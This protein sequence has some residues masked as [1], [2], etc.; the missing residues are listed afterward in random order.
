M[1][2]ELAFRPKL[3]HT[4]V[5]LAAR[6]PPSNGPLILVHD[7]QLDLNLVAPSMEVL[8]FLERGGLPSGRPPDDATAIA[9]LERMRADGASIIAF[10]AWPS[11]WWLDHYRRFHGISAPDR[12]RDTA[13][14]AAR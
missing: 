5:D 3:V 14:G 8:P 12:R 10:A 11:F 7:H 9:E 13:G 4:A 2:A 6:L 1:A